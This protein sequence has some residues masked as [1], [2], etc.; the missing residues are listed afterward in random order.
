MKN[1]IP[2]EKK[3]DIGKPKVPVPRNILNDLLE[4]VKDKKKTS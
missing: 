4:K 2:V 3:S 1:E